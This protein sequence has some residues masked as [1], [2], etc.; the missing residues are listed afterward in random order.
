MKNNICLFD[1]VQLMSQENSPGKTR[2]KASAAE[3][4]SPEKGSPSKKRDE[5]NQ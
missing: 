5:V 4:G 2:G 1:Q 3:D